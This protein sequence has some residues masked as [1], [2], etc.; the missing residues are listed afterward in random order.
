M[1]A[2]E[3]AKKLATHFS[4]LDEKPVG[5][6]ATAPLELAV[7]DAERRDW[8]V[9]VV[10]FE[11]SEEPLDRGDMCREELVVKVVVNGPTKQITR[12]KGIELS[13]FLRDS[14]R[15]TEFDGFRWAGNETELLYDA[16]AFKSSGQFLSVF[17][18]TYFTFN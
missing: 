2:E 16:D 1:H 4:A 12:A 6:Q 13:K 8:G 14:L 17:R 15:E 11:E 5:F 3:L 7:A 18:A 10:P 9:F